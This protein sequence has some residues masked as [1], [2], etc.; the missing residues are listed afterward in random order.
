M[1][2]KIL[3][4]IVAVAIAAITAVNVNFNTP[5][6]GAATINLSNVEALASG[7]ISPC[8][9]G[10]IKDGIGCYCYQWYPYYK[11]AQW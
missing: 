3:G 1:K 11:E 10:C 8:P 5:N 4:G 2:K 9:N 7:E 6:N